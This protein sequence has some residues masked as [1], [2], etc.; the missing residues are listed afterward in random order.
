MN[1]HTSKATIKRHCIL[2]FTRRDSRNRHHL[3]CFAS[4]LELDLVKRWKILNF[5]LSHLMVFYTTLGWVCTPSCS[6]ECRKR[7]NCI[8]AFVR[9]CV[10]VL[11]T[12]IPFSLSY[13][14]CCIFFF[15][16]FISSDSGM[17]SRAW[18]LMRFYRMRNRTQCHIKHSNLC[19]AFEHTNR[20]LLLSDEKLT[21]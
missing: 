18:S 19:S 9:S 8:P 21:V 2:R 20:S 12:G 11:C 7:T 15:Q 14:R 5:S 17:R 6:G 13:T 16:I 1:K 4:I 3:V 10:C